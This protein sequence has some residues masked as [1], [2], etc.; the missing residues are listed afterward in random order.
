LVESPVKSTLLQVPNNNKGGSVAIAFGNKSEKR[1]FN[2]SCINW[3]FQNE[4]HSFE[5]K[6][7]QEVGLKEELM[8]FIHV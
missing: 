5:V 4:S 7:D 6:L 3:N 2:D 1:G 8:Q